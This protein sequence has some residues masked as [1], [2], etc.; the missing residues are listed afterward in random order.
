MTGIMDVVSAWAIPV[1]VLVILVYAAWKGI[2]VFETFVEGGR[3]GFTIAIGLIPYMVAMLVGLG[4]FRESGAF[5]LLVKFLKPVTSLLGI[6][7]EVLPLALMRPISGNGAL[8]IAAETMQR[9]GPDS[10]I[11][12]IACTMQGS[13]DTTFYILTVYF[14]SVGVKNVRY[15]LKVG[16]LADLAGFVASVFVC[17]LFFG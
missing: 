3:E 13:T 2:P 7:G 5:A 4:I 12:L 16:L 9:Y 6:P 15:S 10:L 1:L 17:K 8:A 11:G 14:G